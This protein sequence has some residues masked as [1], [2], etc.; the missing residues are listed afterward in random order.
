ML[1]TKEIKIRIT[2]NVGDY[3]RKNNID[4]KFNEYNDLPIELVNPQSH[5]IVDAV[6]DVCGKE[7]KVQYRRYNQSVNRGGYYTCSSKCGKD[8]REKTFIDRYGVDSAF[9]TDIFKKK[10]RETNLLRWGAEHFRQ[11]EK[12]QNENGL[13]ERQKRKETVFNQFLSENPK[14]IGQDENHFM[15]NCEIH[16]ESKIPKI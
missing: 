5:L 7:V 3:Y 14:V 11:S 4:V 10:Y 16:G 9:K 12:W 6:C 8:K 15:I 1:L 2:G 13:I